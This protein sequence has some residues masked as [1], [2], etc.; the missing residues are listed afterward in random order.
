[1]PQTLQNDP[2]LPLSHPASVLAVSLGSSSRYPS[3]AAA[4]PF[5]AA[6]ASHLG[7][8]STLPSCPSDVVLALFNLF[9]IAKMILFKCDSG[10]VTP[11]R[12]ILQCFLSS[13]RTKTNDLTNVPSTNLSESYR[14]PEY[15][16][17]WTSLTQS[18]PVTLV[19][20]VYLTIPRNLIPQEIC[21]FFLEYVFP[22]CTFRFHVFQT[23]VQNNFI[24]VDLC[25]IAVLLQNYHLLWYI[26]FQMELT[27]IYS[28]CSIRT[29]FFVL[30]FPYRLIIRN[31]VCT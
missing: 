25:K 28:V 16:S 3:P 27:A 8:R 29:Y 13:L 2:V 31:S 19:S 9:A 6:I 23:S 5:P 24:I 18:R 1:M 20:L 4:A 22:R 26:F 14:L 11:L 17:Y 7:H 30:F 15:I 10:N 21:I 12:R